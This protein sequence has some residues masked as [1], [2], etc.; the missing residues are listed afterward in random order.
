M[1]ILADLSSGVGQGV[2]G[3][4]V[5]CHTKLLVWSSALESASI[6]SSASS[7]STSP[8]AATEDGRKRSR[9]GQLQCF[10]CGQCKAPSE[11]SKTQ[12]RRG[13]ARRCKPCVAEGR[14]VEGG[15]FVSGGGGGKVSAGGA[16]G[17]Q[18]KV[19]EILTRPQ[20]AVPGFP[21]L[22]V[23]ADWGKKRMPK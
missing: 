3:A 23:A 8:C 14:Q 6:G 19:V 2:P 18:A 20:K 1:E 15:R 7:I 22:T 4:K 12:R 10:A 17:Q 9:E 21:G 13:S 11:F 5:K 16:G